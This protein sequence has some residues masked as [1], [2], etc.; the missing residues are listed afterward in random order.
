MFEK[1]SNALKTILST[2]SLIQNVS[3]YEAS[4]LEGFPA[5][6]ITPAANE[7]AYNSTSENRRVYAYMVR[8]YVIRNSGADEESE[9]EKT[10]RLLVDTVLDTIDKNHS[11]LNVA[12][13]TG[14]T[15][16]F[17]HAAPSQW[18]YA[19]AANE[20]R[21][22]EIQVRVEYDVDVNLIS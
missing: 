2:N 9:C 15:F 12:S 18:G 10:M 6:T 20:M 1:V 14:Y 4:K 11:A 5:M 8:L 21:V 13:Q 17:M 19:G 22:A 3:D 16:L 7:N